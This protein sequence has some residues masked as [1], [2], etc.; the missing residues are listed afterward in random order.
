MKRIFKYTA[1]AAAISMFAAGCSPENLK[2]ASFNLWQVDGITVTPG[3]GCATVS[4]VPQDGKPD[5][6]EYIISWT[7]D[8]EE[9]EAGSRNVA[10]DIHELM[11]DNLANDCEYTF[12]VQASY[13]DGL[14][15]KVTAAATPKSTRIAASDFR[16]IAGNGLAVLSWTEPETDLQ[17]SYEIVISSTGTGSRTEKLESGLSRYVAEDLVNGT[18]YT[19]GLTC[20]YGHGNSDTVTASATPGDIQAI[21]TDKTNLKQFELAVF[22]YNPAYF[23][24]DEVAGV[25][26]DFGD[27]S[28]SSEETA[29]HLF[30]STG[31]YTVKITVTYADNSTQ[32]ASADITVEP[33][34]WSMASIGTGYL[35]A[36]NIVFSHDGQTFY[37]A[38]ADAPR[39]L[40]AFSA[41]SGEQLWTYPVSAAVYGEGPAVGPDGTIYFAAEDNDGT[42]YAISPDGKLKWSKALGKKIQSSPAVTSDGTVYVLANEGVFKALDA[43]TGNEKW[44]AEGLG[45]TAGGVAVDADGTVYIGANPGIWAYTSEGSLKWKAAKDYAVSERGGSL[46]I[47]DGVL[48]ATLKSKGGCVALNTADGSELWQF[49]SEEND[50]YHPVVDK[51]GTVYFCEKNGNVY[52]VTKNGAEKWSTS[53]KTGYTYSGFALGADGKAYISQYGGDKNLVRFDMESGNI[54]T[55]NAIG[56]QSMSPVSIGPDNRA[57]FGI[58]GGNIHAVDIR[59]S[60][61]SEGWPMRGCNMQGTNSLK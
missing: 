42:V 19:F 35:K 11:I 10:P 33:F 61:A 31:N 15:M 54:E 30:T 28:T 27:G 43:A 48:Y 58:K 14:S 18:E 29:S 2:E 45:S 44:S 49:K 21:I 39:G 56:V 25:S 36:S 57:Y 4:W 12:G 46:A 5:P 7:P 51:D 38:S 59:T 3:D 23:I 9:M 50:C 55:V 41:I 13:E 52:A 8:N 47:H 32:D 16:A 40:F 17:Y 20:V 37:A 60:I 1:A 6:A 34:G 22:E 53:D 26:W 24:K